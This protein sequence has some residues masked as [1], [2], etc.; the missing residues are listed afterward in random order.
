MLLEVE[1]IKDNLGISPSRN[2]TLK[3]VEHILKHINDDNIYIIDDF[4]YEFLYYWLQGWHDGKTGA[5]LNKQLPSFLINKEN[6]QTIGM[7]GYYEGYWDGH[8]SFINDDD[9]LINDIFNR[10]LNNLNLKYEIYKKGE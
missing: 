3:C 8:D 6:N 9:K 2:T 5:Y 1:L 7:L 4:A 10:L